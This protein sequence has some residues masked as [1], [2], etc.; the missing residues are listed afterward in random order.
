MIKKIMIMVIVLML[1]TIIIFAEGQEGQKEK[2][3]GTYQIQIRL[4]SEP[5]K[6]DMTA[7][8]AEKFAEVVQEQSE[9]RIH[10]ELYLGGVLGSQKALQEQVILGTI[11]SVV[12]SSDIVSID[13]KFGI[14]DFPFLFSSSEEVYNLLDGDLGMA[15]NQSL[16]EKQGV[17][18][19]AFGELGFRQITNNVRPIFTPS[20]LRGI[21]LRVPPTQ[22]RIACFEAL[23]ASPTP[24]AWAELYQALSQGVVDGQ[25]NPISAILGSSFY[26]VQTYLSI[27]NHVYSP[28]YLLVNEAWWQG[29]SSDI[30]SILESSAKETVAW[31]RAYG[32]DLD[33]KMLEQL[34]EKGMIVNEIDHAA[35]VE[36]AKQV[37]EKYSDFVG[38]ELVEMVLKQSVKY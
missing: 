31:Q 3:E 34:K 32:R 2:K 5:S 33:E 9:G 38:R 25:E 13:P 30:R 14:F 18:V 4:A 15:L 24:V 8:L 11:E 23:G 22:L 12:T 29:L 20:D 16:I 35:F 28:A 10:V 7:L 26:D 27:S 6:P 21:R 37:W 1:A 36:N 19:L 17:R